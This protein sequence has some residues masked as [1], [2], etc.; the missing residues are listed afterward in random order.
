MQAHRSRLAATACAVVAVWFAGASLHAVPVELIVNGDFESGLTG[1]TA[2][3][4]GTSV[5]AAS[6]N[7]PAGVPVPVNAHGG[8]LM[9]AVPA[10]SLGDAALVQSVNA[11]G[12]TNLQMSFAFNAQALDT[13]IVDN[14]TDLMV[15]NLGP[16]TFPLTAGFADAPDPQAQLPSTRGWQTLSFPLPNAFALPNLTVGFTVRNTVFLGGENNQLFTGYIDDVSLTGERVAVVPEP[17]T[18]ALGAMALGGIGLACRR[19]MRG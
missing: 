11:S 14:G 4:G 3:P 1:W 9:G 13:D 10:G 7:I 19:R 6:H 18:V 5:A 15:L 2:I 12:L 8:S 16:L 17:G